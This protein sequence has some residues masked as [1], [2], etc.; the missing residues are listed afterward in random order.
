LNPFDRPEASVS[1]N[2]LYSG[3]GYAWIYDVFQN[4]SNFW[5]ARL[6]VDVKPVDKVTAQ[7]LVAY[8]EV[9]E[10]FDLPR[11]IHVGRYRVPVWPE[12]AFWTEESSQ[13]LGVLTYVWAQYNYTEDLFIRVGWEH[14]FPGDGFEDGNFTD[15]HGL[16]FQGGTDDDGADYLFF[17]TG[18]SF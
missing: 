9:N 7:F 2:R 14:L 4:T 3:K 17:D 6:G 5:Q 8:Q 11:M 13:D 10:P 16:R 12:L 1:F 15:G 18:V